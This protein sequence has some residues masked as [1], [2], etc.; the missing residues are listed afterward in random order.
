VPLGEGLQNFS[1]LHFTI[2][3]PTPTPKD[4]HIEAPIEAPNRTV[5]DYPFDT[6]PLLESHLHPKFVIFNSG[7]KLRGLEGLF[8]YRKLLD[9][10]PILG[11]VEKVYLAWLES[12]LPDNVEDDESYN[13]AAD[14]DEDDDSDVIVDD[15]RDN[16][17]VLDKRSMKASQKRKFSPRPR[18]SPTKRQ[19]PG[20]NRKVLSAVISNIEPL[21][22]VRL[23][24]HNRQIGGAAWTHDRIRRWS[25]P[26]HKKRKLGPSH[27][28]L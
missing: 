27:S 16:D 12:L 17:Y 5:H 1:I 21:S 24:S 25:R 23:S 10:F 20:A 9:K 2:T 6:L 28:F 7:E 15:P 14:S 19:K 3:R 11:D 13:A 18:R 4:E 26:L 22:E 8:E